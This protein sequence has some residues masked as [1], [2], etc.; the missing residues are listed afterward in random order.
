MY[1]ESHRHL[2]GSIK[3]ETIWE[4][5]VD[6]CDLSIAKSLYDVRQQV[7]LMRDDTDFSYFCTRLDILNRLEWSDWALCKIARQA[8]SDIKAENIKH[9]TLTVSLNKFIK[10][11]DLVITG[12]RVFGIL[13]TIAEEIGVDVN[14]LLSISYGWPIE[15][16]LQMLD[17]IKPLGDLVAGVDFVG[18]ESLARWQEYG[19]PLELWRQEDKTVRVHIAERPE[20]SDNLDLALMYMD[21]TRIA[22]GIYTTEEQQL[23]AIRRGIVFDMSLHSNIYTHAIALNKHPIK[24]MQEIGCKITLGTDDPVQFNCSIQNEYMLAEAMGVD[25]ES[26]R[27]T[28]FES[29]IL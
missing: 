3:P 20:T 17:L 7:C 29:R 23:E 4:I 24:K 25:K 16:Q 19:E 8:L 12:Y 18:D 13:D 9:C 26:I 14:Y 28:A 1:A 11:D 2:S 6:S 21:I 15:L 27:Q 22:H 5:I 10:S